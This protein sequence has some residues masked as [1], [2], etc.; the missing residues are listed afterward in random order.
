MYSLFQEKK[1]NYTGELALFG[2]HDFEKQLLLDYGRLTDYYRSRNYFIRNDHLL[3]R[4]INTV[5]TPLAYELDRYYDITQARSLFVANAFKMTSSINYGGWFKGV[6]YKDCPELIIAYDG[7]SDDPN[8]LALNW[9][10]I[11]AVRVLEHPL[12]NLGL[13]LPTGDNE[14]T[15]HGLAVISIDIPKLMVQYREFMKLQY[16]NYQADQTAMQTTQQFVGKYVLPNMVKSQTDLVLLNRIQA[17]YYGEPLA[18]PLASHPFFISDYSQ[19]FDN[20]A[21]LVLKRF[22]NS[23][24]PYEAYVSQFPS[25][26]SNFALRMPDTATTRQ[27]WWAMFLTR[28]R[29]ME[30]IIDLGGSEGVR[31]SGRDITQLQIDVRRFRSSGEFNQRMPEDLDIEMNAFFRKVMEL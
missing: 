9:R 11:D 5:A 6:F 1:R 23:R 26:F 20:V 15:E 7:D 18:K 24:F 8:E 17:L 19:R 31:A 10:E 14:M 21:K 2:L 13:L 25:I 30:F 4:L 27:V 29:V 12:T 22:A 28:K 3:V 16:L